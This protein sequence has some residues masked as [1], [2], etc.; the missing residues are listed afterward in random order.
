MKIGTLVKV[1]DTPS[2]P[3]ACLGRFG[4]VV[5]TEVFDELVGYY[6]NSSAVAV[7]FNYPGED[8]LETDVWLFDEEDL[9]EVVV[10]DVPEKVYSDLCDHYE[11]FVK[12][13]PEHFEGS[14]KKLPDKRKG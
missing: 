6:T 1:I 3:D 14:P 13:S 10:K 11:Y 2:S 4:A 12:V 7:A 9:V 8:Y 5:P